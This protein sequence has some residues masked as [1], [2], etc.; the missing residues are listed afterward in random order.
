LL[1]LDYHKLTYN[2]NGLDEKLTSVYEAN[3]VQG[4]LA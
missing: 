1:G 4:I 3:V 2:V